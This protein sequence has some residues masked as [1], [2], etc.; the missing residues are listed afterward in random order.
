MGLSVDISARMQGEEHI[1]SVVR[2]AGVLDQDTSLVADRETK[3]LFAGPPRVVVFD[4][5]GV[6]FVTSAGISWLLA[7]RRTLEARHTMVYFSS[8]Q[9]AVR[10]VLEIMKAL[11]MSSVFSSETELDA[12]LAEIQ[13]KVVDGEE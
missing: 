1:S 4:L 2:L 9:P 7:S 8:P 6:T 3:A 11:P 5:A 10:K 12:Y 13:R